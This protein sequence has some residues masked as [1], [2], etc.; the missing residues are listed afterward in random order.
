MLRRIVLLVLLSGGMLAVADPAWAAT[1]TVNSP[2]D[3]N[4]LDFPGGAFDGSSDGNCDITLSIAGNQCTLR[5]AI[6]ASNVNDN[7]PTVD[8]IHFNIPGDGPHTIAPASEGLPTVEE[9]VTIDGYTQGDLTSPTT[10]DARENTLAF[11][12]NADLRIELRGS[13]ANLGSSG[14]IISGGGTTIRGLVITQFQENATG[15][16]GFGIVFSDT[17][18]NT[19]NRVEGNF[20]GTNRAGTTPEPNDGAGVRFG[21]ASSGNTVGGA[22]PD[23]RNLI[24]ANGKEGVVLLSDANTIRGNLIGTRSDGTGDLGNGRRGILVLF[25]GDNNLISENVIAFNGSAGVDIL[26]SDA[27]NNRILTN[28]I[29]SNAGLAIDLVGGGREQDNKDPDTGA[30]NLQNF[31]VLAS[32]TTT[33]TAATI[34]GTLNSRP[35]KTFTIQFFQNPVLTDEGK[36]FLG[37]ISVKTNK[38]GKASFTFLGPAIDRGQP[39]TATATGLDGTSEFSDPVSVGTAS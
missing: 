4:D 21:P 12:T 32:A 39:I 28:S 9:P 33:G 19:A 23:K 20:I 5:A 11:G 10:D 30:N 15:G 8:A 29:F 26:A 6:Q 35:R 38:R 25:R 34:E 36:T 18:G 1:F 7:A 17:E 27:V 24:S 31:P 14:L 2:G 22:T 37:Q 13:S 16:G 3:E